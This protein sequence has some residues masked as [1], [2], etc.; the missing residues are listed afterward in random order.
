[1]I[2]IKD[3]LNQILSNSLNEEIVDSI[4]QHATILELEKNETLV[5]WGEIKKTVYIILQGSLTRKILNKDG[6]EKTV[7]FHTS[8]FLPIVTC[9]DS[10]VLNKRT[11]YSLLINE[12]ST[13]LE[14]PFDFVNQLLQESHEFAMFSSNYV[15]YKYYII[16]NI[17]GELLSESSEEFLRWLYSNYSF[18]FQIFPLSSISSFMGITPEWLSKIRRKLFS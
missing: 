16:E 3:R 9:I 6:I 1:M 15:T 10:Y 4:I 14:V 12:R 8:E 13:I 18:L 11:E 17:R 5:S 7:M 2:S